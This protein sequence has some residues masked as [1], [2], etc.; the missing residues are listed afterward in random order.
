MGEWENGT[1]TKYESEMWSKCN[2]YLH[3]IFLFDQHNIKGV[4]GLQNLQHFRYTY[5][6]L[7][8]CN[9]HDG[10]FTR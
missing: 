2:T 7:D 4:L 5:L 1:G 3:E 10:H 6:Y 8:I 9:K